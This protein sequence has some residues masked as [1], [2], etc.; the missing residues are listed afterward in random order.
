MAVEI[1]IFGEIK[2][3]LIHRL[4][5]EAFLPNPYGHPCVNHKDEDKCNNC[6]DNL[7]WC[8]YSY[9]TTY[10]D[11]NSRRIIT[12]HIN[13]PNNECYKRGMATRKLNK[14]WNAEQRVC[15]MSDNITIATFASMNEASRI[16]GIRSSHISECCRGKRKRAGGFIWCYTDK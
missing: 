3:R 8:T 5:A 6:V 16:T 13:N 12:R 14:T 10:N 15:Q 11:G 9:N 4:V 2:M 1:S 7:E